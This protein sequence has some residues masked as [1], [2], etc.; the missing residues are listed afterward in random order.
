MVSLKLNIYNYLKTVL[1]AFVQ[2]S[3]LKNIFIDDYSQEHLLY[4]FTDTILETNIKIADQTPIKDSP[5]INP[6]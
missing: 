6:S 1:I 5:F 4:N 2:A 3:I